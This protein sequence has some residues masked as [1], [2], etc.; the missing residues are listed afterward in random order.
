MNTDV[1]V[2]SIFQKESLHDCS[3]E[4]LQNLA[5][6]YPYF[7]PVQLLL[8]EKLRSSNEA[9]YQQ[10]LQTLS[11]HFNNLLWLDFLL[12]R[13]QTGTLEEQKQEIE[14]LISQKASVE[15]NS[16]P[17]SY[18]KSASEI[19][20]P[21]SEEINESLNN[22]INV[23]ADETGLQVEEQAHTETPVEEI[24]A[25]IENTGPFIEEISEPLNEYANVSADETGLQVEEQAHTETPVE[26]ITTPIENTGPFIEEIS[27]PSNE[28]ANVS[29]DETGIQAGAQDHFEAP[30]EEITTPIENTGPIEEHINEPFNEDVNGPADETPVQQEHQGTEETHETP[31]E[32]DEQINETKISIPHHDL[33]QE[34]A[35][36]EL[37][38]EPYYTIDYFASQGIKFIPEDKPADR[39]GQQLKSF[40]EW[41]KAMKRL[42]QTEAVKLPE[43]PVEEK[44]LQL[45][46]H[47]IDEDDV[48]TEA[49]AEVWVKQGNKEKAIEI[50]NKLSLLNPA[51]SA[52]FAALTEQLKNS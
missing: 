34:P 21:T 42:P 17:R 33:D 37:K 44:V 5:S 24:K 12:N 35:E 15:E 27:E 45:A 50:Y 39:F 20:E 4:E 19:A 32:T 36:T 11:L 22:N 7:T 43:S 51:K 48:V 30:V 6:Q 29:A 38:F 23:P 41:L 13:Y 40:T 46:G 10:K 14:N 18:I 1:L 26:E 16:E 3:I 28:H 9:L 47:S 49:M 25:P 52:Y 31:V 2:R 8:A